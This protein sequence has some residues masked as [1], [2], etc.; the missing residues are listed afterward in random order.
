VGFLAAAAWYVSALHWS[1]WAV[2]FAVAAVGVTLT[3]SVARY[4]L[5]ERLRA[6]TSLPTASTETDEDRS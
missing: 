2:V 1:E 3:G 6:S 5:A 4:L